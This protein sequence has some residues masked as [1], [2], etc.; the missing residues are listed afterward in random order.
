MCHQHP[1]GS[2][3]AALALGAFAVFNQLIRGDTI[4]H[5]GL[6]PRRV[7]RET[8]V[9]QHQ[10]VVVH[11]HPVVVHQPPAIVYYAPRPRVHRYERHRHVP[12]GHYSK[13][14]KRWKHSK[15]DDD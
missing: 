8:V 15:H 13:H 9:V 6:G 4:F 12:P 7:I 3:D 11:Q 1:I 2:T 10:P 14:W 5:G